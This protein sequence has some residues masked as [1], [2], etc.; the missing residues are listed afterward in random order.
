MANSCFHCGG[1]IIWDSDF[2]YEDL[3]LEGQG[4]VHICH[5]PDCGAQIEF[6]VPME[7][8]EDA[9]DNA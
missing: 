7:S 9:D 4:I 6:R 8:E 5:C 1:M 3:G 2:D